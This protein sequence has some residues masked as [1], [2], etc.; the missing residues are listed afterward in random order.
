MKTSR[1]AGILTLLSFFLLS[2]ACPGVHGQTSLKPLGQTVA[3]SA[4]A[5]RRLGAFTNMRY[6]AEHQYGY[7]VELW[8]EKD[9]LF[10]FLLVS[11]GLAGDTPTGL[12]EDV[13]FDPKTGRLT[14]RAR[15]STASTFD[16]N[17]RQVPTRDLYEFNGALK[18]QSL[19]GTL[20]HTDAP[21]RSA[22]GTKTKVSLRRSKSGSDAMIQP[23]NYG[24]WKEE[25]DEI[26]KLRGPKW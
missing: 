21:N 20:R 19:T 24:E 9:R 17:N 25:A 4:G 23:K 8:Q 11:A 14:F 7:S 5:V 2:A 13:V 16:E 18:G 3:R 1:T 26:L 12:L 15:L 6:T 10:G 22:A